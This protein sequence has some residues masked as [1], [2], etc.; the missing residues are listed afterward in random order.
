MC[1]GGCLCVRVHA[2]VSY[3][4]GF[5]VSVQNVDEICDSQHSWKE[6]E[7]DSERGGCSIPFYHHLPVY[8]G[9][10]NAFEPATN[11]TLTIARKRFCLSVIFL[12][13]QVWGQEHARPQGKERVDSMKA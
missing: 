12:V 6:K 13:C 5:I 10:S 11:R 7:A 1:V 9:L 2:S 8:A 3:H 4:R